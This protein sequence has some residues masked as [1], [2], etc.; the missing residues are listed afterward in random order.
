[1][2][3]G[4]S[5]IELERR[6]AQH[7]LMP[8]ERVP[9]VTRASTSRALLDT[10]SCALAG[11]RSPECRSLISLYGDRGGTPES[12]VTGNPTRFPAPF[13]ATANSALA[14]WY[15][16]DDLHDLA[17]VHAGAVIWPVLAAAAEATG[18]DQREAGKELVATA[19]AAFDIAGR[20]GGMLAPNFD[21]RWFSTAPAGAAAAAAG[22]ARLFGLDEAGVHAAMGL[23]ATASGLSRAPLNE[24]VTGKNALCGQTVAAVW[25]AVDMAR[26]GIVGAPHFLTGPNGLV[27]LLSAGRGEI[28]RSF[29]DLGE[30]FSID[31]MSIKPYPCCRA[32]HPTIDLALD[33]CADDPI[34]AGTV[35]SVVALV[36]Q[37]IYDVVGKPFALGTNPRLSAQFSIPYTV[38][39]ALLNG[40]IRLGDF[41]SETVFAADR[42]RTLASRIKVEP[43]ALSRGKTMYQTS[44]TLRFSL[45]NGEVIERSTAVVKGYR[46]RPLTS[47]ER[48]MK[49]A[50]CAEGRLS[51][52]D[53]ARLTAAA[54][55]IEKSG[56]HPFI[57]LLRDAT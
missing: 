11:L 16:W 32:T 55:E 51:S 17:V 35:E 4:R 46:D 29:D 44:V 14:H 53:Q 7:A 2:K 42:V 12:S 21:A 38:A 25:A 57:S 20:I 15:E 22:A 37:A 47:S 40:R 27:A 43:F 33:F 28:R 1:M 56:L 49:L 23:A 39:L 5:K 9:A 10:F 19:V 6:L 13:A 41:D 30:R 34:R 54:A 36:N 48:A 18:R 50:D 8:I 3:E 52:S 45:R 31:E 26:A 24:R